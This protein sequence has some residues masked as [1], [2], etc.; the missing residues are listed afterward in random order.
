[1]STLFQQFTNALAMGC[2]YG[3][4]AIG[5]SM[6]YGILQLINFA[7][8]SVF[9]FSM[10]FAFYSISVFYLPW[11]FGLIVMILLTILLGICIQ[12]VAYQPLR[13]A[14]R[15]SLTIS[16]I[17][18]A[19]LL[20]NLATVVFTAVPKSFPEIPFLQ[21]MIILGNGEWRVQRLV[22][23]VI[24]S[25]VIL[26]TALLF[27]LDHTK[28]GIAT[29][30]VSK[31]FET[32]QLMGI[33]INAVIRVTFVIGSGLTAFGAFMWGLKYPQ[34]SPTVGS[35][36]GTK[37]FIAAVIGGIGNIKGAVLGGIILGLTEIMLVYF[38][39]GLSGYRDIFA[40]IIL[41]LIL[42]FKPTGLFSTKITDKA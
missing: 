4:V 13:S 33:N 1:M 9:M 10:Y 26:I 30:A 39:P 24:V 14:P 41:I 31:D 27:F 3:L 36:P 42:L 40:F 6:V 34:I 38:F 25:M 37:C 23:F 28:M 35:M 18:V 12:R 5:Y 17:G 32:S 22:I 2:L 16:A 21:E 8:S 20:E 29:K 7:N 11:Y 15:I 19:Y